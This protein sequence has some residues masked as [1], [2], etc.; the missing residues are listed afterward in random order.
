M[1]RLAPSLVAVL[2]LAGSPLL[3]AATFFVRPDGGPP[4]RCDGKSNVAA[5][6][7]GTNQPCAWDHPFR[8]LPPDG[9]PRIGAGDTLIVGSGSYMMGVGAPGA[10]NC[11]A[12]GAW[13]C[14][15]PPIPSGPSASQP[16]RILGAG[17]D[18]GCPSPPQLWGTER[19]NLVINLD[20]ASNVEIG[21]FE[22]TDH[23]T[24]VEFHSGSIPCQRDTPPYGTWAADGLYAADSKNV[25]L[26]DLNIHGFAS[27]GVRAGRLTDW[28]VERVRIAGNGAAGWDGDLMGT[29]SNSGTLTFRKFTVEWNGCGETYPGGQPTGCWAQSAGGYGD[30]FGTGETAGTWIFEDSAFLH[31]TSDGLDLLY[32]RT[33]SSISIIRTRAEGNAGNQLKTNGPAVIENSIVVGNCAFF[34]GKSFTLNVDPCRALGNSISLSLRP[35]DQV[36]VV[37]N[38]ISGQGDCLATAGCFGGGACNGTERVRF[39]NN[40]FVGGPEFLSPD[41][42]TCLIYQEEFPQGNALFDADYHFVTGI[43]DDDCPGEH[44]ICNVDPGLVSSSLS[45]FD[46][47][48][49]STSPV[50]GFASKADAPALDFDRALRDSAP[51]LGAYEYR[52]GGGTCTLTCSATAP[53]SALTGT[54]VTFSATAQANGCA[55]APAFD[56]DFGDGTPHGSGATVTHAYTGAGAKNWRLLVST[57]GIS[58]TQTGTVQ[59]SASTAASYLVP[60][61]THS[62]GAEGSLWRS[63]LTVVNRASVQASLAFSFVPSTGPVRTAEEKITA[64]GTREWTDVLT[65]LL[66]FDRAAT[67]SGALHL[68]SDQPLVVTS[69]TYDQKE[70]ATFGGGLTAVTPATALVAGTIGILPQLKKSERY[71]TN[72][73][74]GNLMSD[75]ITVEIRLYGEGGQALGHEVSVNLPPSGFVQVTDVFAAAEAPDTTLAYATVEVKTPGGKAG[76]YASVIDNGSNDPTIVPLSLP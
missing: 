25:R 73:G 69:R 71:R 43:K 57:S 54:L 29:D 18:T 2:T 40:I 6:A 41:D 55:A 38:T 5:P 16:T 64:R 74:F 75:S 30:G 45:S 4:E 32:A 27:T 11:D 63:D 65:S 39:R 14:H 10:T 35:G 37:N 12:E 47:H 76:I 67:I 7:S 68:S 17:W 50:I 59:V 13:G 9:A 53:A 70:N 42:R 1:P 36:R 28:T 21:C 22:I 34:E 56:W 24:C 52:T 51:D 31:N 62:P 61:V 44:K 8:A 33:G 72:I 3:E 66:G 23:S 58:C 20:R 48:L 26:F 46:A 15:M 19:A 60:A 49:L